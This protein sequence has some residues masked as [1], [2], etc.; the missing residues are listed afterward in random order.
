[1]KKRIVRASTSSWFLITATNSG[2]IADSSRFEHRRNKKWVTLVSAETRRVTPK[3]G[4]SV[5]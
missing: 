4:L 2:L 5:E 1:M 3:M